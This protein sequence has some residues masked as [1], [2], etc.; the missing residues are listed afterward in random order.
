[1]LPNMKEAVLHLI[2]AVLFLCM[3]SSLWSNTKKTVVQVTSEV[4]VSEDVDYIIKNF[5]E[6]YQKQQV[7]LYC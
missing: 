5:K 3:P 4:T 2:L 7:F 6:C 1:M